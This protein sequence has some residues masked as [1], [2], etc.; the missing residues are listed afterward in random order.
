VLVRSRRPLG[1]VVA[2]GCARWSDRVAQTVF[3]EQRTRSASF[4]PLIGS[5]R[6]DVT[7]GGKTGP[8]AETGSSST[9]HHRLRCQDPR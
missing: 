3:G 1:F 6:G 4:T 8:R 9:S 5:R 2:Q 7:L